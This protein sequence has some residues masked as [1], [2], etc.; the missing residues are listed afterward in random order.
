MN[1]I[2]GERGVGT[3]LNHNYNHDD[4]ARYD[5]NDN[6]IDMIMMMTIM[7]IWGGERGVSLDNNYQDIHHND[8]SEGD[9]WKYD[10]DDDDDDY[11]NDAWKE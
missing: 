4:D 5:N 10:D 8:A 3:W 2:R 11:R 9:L 6:S 1:V 7:M